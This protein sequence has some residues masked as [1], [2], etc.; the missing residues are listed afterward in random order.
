MA[1]LDWKDY[2]LIGGLGLG[3]LGLHLYGKHRLNKAR[4]AFRESIKE[5]SEEEFT[6][7]DYGKLRDLSGVDVN[8][9][10]MRDPVADIVGRDNAFFT[11]DKRA[12]S[13]AKRDLLAAKVKSNDGFVALG[14]EDKGMA[15]LAHELG[16]GKN[17]QT[18]DLRDRKL[19]Q[20][21]WSA[22]GTVSGIL[23]G[24]GTRYAIN[25]AKAQAYDVPRYVNILPMLTGTLVAST[26]DYIGDT[27]GL[28]EEDAASKHA[29]K[30]LKEYGRLPEELRRDRKSLNKALDTYREGRL[31]HLLKSVGS[32]LGWGA[33]LYGA[34]RV[35]NFY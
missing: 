2:A 26:G 12:R 17:S 32:G 31:A 9:G 29:I 8:V 6:P 27:Y 18:G 28:A 15:T 23:A 5:L 10:E 25:R 3:G 14:P 33:L 35:G 24:L 16:H 19:K 21:L 4:E 7:E 1:S 30:F 34:G 11:A 20:F 22:G 13:S